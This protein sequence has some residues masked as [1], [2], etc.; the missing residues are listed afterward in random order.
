MYARILVPLDGSAV[1]EA[2]L[3]HAVSMAN[4]FHADLYLLRSA[5]LS[6]FP[7]HELGEARNTL[8]QESEVYLNEV[9]CLLRRQGHQVHTTARWGK[10]AET[11]LEYVG[12]QHISV[13]VMATHG[14][15]SLH[16]WPMGSIAEK[17]LHS[18]KVPVLLIR[19]T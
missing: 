6:P 11:I 17:V 15:S 12:E 1:S 13:V 16:Q 2:A 7:T 18:M 4:L 8:L 5:F 9:A 10:A 19:E 3:A 14:H